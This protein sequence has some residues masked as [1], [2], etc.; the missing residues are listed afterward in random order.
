MDTFDVDIAK[1][2][3][4]TPIDSSR[5]GPDTT[6]VSDADVED[7][8]GDRSAEAIGVISKGGLT[9]PSALNETTRRQIGMYVRSAAALDV[10]DKMGFSDEQQRRVLRQECDR[11]Y[12][13][14]NSA[15][16]LATKRTRTRS[17]VDETRRPRIDFTGGFEY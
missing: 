16:L 17:N 3:S 6:P 11:L 12:R 13:M 1:V 14:L 2:L 4:K 7:Y 10:L 9:D 5:I 8:I 15:Q